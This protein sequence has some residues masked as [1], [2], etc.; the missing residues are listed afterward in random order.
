MHPLHSAR[1]REPAETLLATIG[2]VLADG[3]PLRLALLFGSAAR[4]RARPDSDVDLGII[5]LDPA[6]PLRSSPR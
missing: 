1:V 6:L 2:D 4:G 3:P 5:P